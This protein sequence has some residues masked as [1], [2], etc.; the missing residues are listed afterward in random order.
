[1]LV[2]FVRII[3]VGR[4]YTFKQ[5]FINPLQIS[6]IHEDEACKAK[7]KEHIESLN[8]HESTGFSRIKLDNAGLMEE[9]TVV[10]S[11]E[12]IQK[13]IQSNIVIS[14]KQLLRG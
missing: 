3:R 2:P 5:I 11:P 10:G 9:I 8:L 12:M 1:M 7:L 6:Y 4:D 13:K 14:R